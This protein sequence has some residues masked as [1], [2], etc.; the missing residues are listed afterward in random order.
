MSGI[1][2]IIVVYVTLL[3]YFHFPGKSVAYH[4]NC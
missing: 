1:V 2:S 3:V 4:K